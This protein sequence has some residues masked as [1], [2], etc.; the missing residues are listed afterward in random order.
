[1]VLGGVKVE[2]KLCFLR[3][4]TILWV[5]LWMK[6]RCTR[7]ILCF[8]YFLTL[9][10]LPPLRK[11]LRPWCLLYPFLTKTLRR[12]AFSLLSRFSSDIL[13]AWVASVLRTPSFW[14]GKWWDLA[15]RYYWAWVLF[16]N[17][18]WDKEPSSFFEIRTSRKGRHPPNYCSIVNFMEGYWLLRFLKT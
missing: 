7:K 3:I 5:V 4:L 1:M 12:W 9:G 8:G 10:P 13:S 16:W 18:W 17:T 6:G 11:D 14:D 2:G 15:W